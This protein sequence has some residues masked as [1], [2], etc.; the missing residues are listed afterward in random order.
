M[1]V[2][3]PECGAKNRIPDI[4]EPTKTYRCGKCRT[5]LTSG[6]RLSDTKDETVVDRRR[7]VGEEQKQGATVA[8]A[9]LLCL[10]LV[11]L[12]A[13]VGSLMADKIS[14]GSEESLELAMYPND[15]L[16]EVAQEVGQ[17][18][19][20]D[21]QL[22]DLMINTME[23]MDGDGLSA[24]QVGVS[25]RISIVRLDRSST[26][27]EIIVMVNPEIIE[28]EGTVT[29]R[30]GCLSIAGTGINTVEVTRSELI[31]VQYWTLNGEEV[32]REESGW[33]AR[34]I[35]H[36]IDH[37]DGILI[38]DYASACNITPEIIAAI[39]I[40]A[41]AA[42]IKMRFVSIRSMRLTRGKE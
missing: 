37:L 28:R 8:G 2:T 27:E 5:R 15:I 41:I 12:L 10:V 22:A 39:G 18:G 16:D 13:I 19:I 4:P 29:G 6:P 25:R 30:E 24:P 1:I 35:Q 17:I 23:K 38:S 20:E 11:A 36:E 21:W 26:K 9:V 42:F 31:T 40:I 33:N 3:C 14:V 7:V 34:I 32:V